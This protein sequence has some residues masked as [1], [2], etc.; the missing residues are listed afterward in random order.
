METRNPQNLVLFLK[1]M[2]NHKN[3]F[4]TFHVFV[5][6]PHNHSL[7]FNCKNDTKPPFIFDYDSQLCSEA[8]RKLNY[9]NG[10]KNLY[11]HEAKAVADLVTFTEEIL[12]GELL[13]L[14][15]VISFIKSQ[16]NYCQWIRKFPSKKII[17]KIDSVPCWTIVRL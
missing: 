7:T 12:N 2:F 8:H 1:K 3:F 13:F 5:C 6:N 10:V 17:K 4:S 9:L 11:D 15:S 16:I 14:T